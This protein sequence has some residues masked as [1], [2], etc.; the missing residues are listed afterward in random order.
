MEH[1]LIEIEK[2]AN[3][4]G[5]RFNWDKTEFYH[6]GRELTSLPIKWGN[7]TLRFRLPMFQYLGHILPSG[8]HG[9]T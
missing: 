3:A 1:A 6:W 5:L 2:V 8:S 7:A 9:S 4:M